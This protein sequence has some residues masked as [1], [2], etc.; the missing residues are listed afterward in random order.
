MTFSA[1][2]AAGNG[3]TVGIEAKRGFT[4]PSVLVIFAEELEAGKA[5]RSAFDTI[6]E[7][8]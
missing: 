3:E 6:E 5:Y 4:K 2:H 7:S 8:S 1:D